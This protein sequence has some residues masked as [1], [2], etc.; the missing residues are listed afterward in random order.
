MGIHCVHVKV[1]S[2][3]D[4]LVGGFLPRTALILIPCQTAAAWPFSDCDFQDGQ[5]HPNYTNHTLLPE[6][7]ACQFQGSLLTFGFVCCSFQ[8]SNLPSVM[9]A[10]T[11]K[12]PFALSDTVSHPWQQQLSQCT[13]TLDVLMP[14]S[15]FP[16]CLLSEY[17]MSSL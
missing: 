1:K 17:L 14:E 15:H 13:A 9:E 3:L 2:D 5:K 16:V 12:S 6:E 4:S 7:N 10:F 11:S 8:T